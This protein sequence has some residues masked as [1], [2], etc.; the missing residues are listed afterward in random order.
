MAKKKKFVKKVEWKWISKKVPFKET[1]THPVYVLM[2]IIYLS[3]IVG[4][5]EW[6][7]KLFGVALIYMF[8]HFVEILPTPKRKITYEEI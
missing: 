1:F 3:V 6:Y 2:I 8:W 4:E 7:G 5:I